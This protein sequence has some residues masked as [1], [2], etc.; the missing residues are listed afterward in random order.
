MTE[1]TSAEAEAPIEEGLQEERPTDRSDLPVFEPD[2]LQD[3]HE[4]TGW[5]E[6]G[7]EHVAFPVPGSGPQLDEG[8]S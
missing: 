8:V 4:S 6:N 3:F 5:P 7:N 1:P 2:M